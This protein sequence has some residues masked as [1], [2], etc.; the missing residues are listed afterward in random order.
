MVVRESRKG[1]R[2][3]TLDV[4]ACNKTARKKVR[5]KENWSMP[6][7]PKEQKKKERKEKFKLN[8]TQV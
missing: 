6:A 5:E 3:K 7:S 1:R 2:R 4:K 8:C